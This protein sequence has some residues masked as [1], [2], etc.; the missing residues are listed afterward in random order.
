MPIEISPTPERLLLVDL[1]ERE[2]HE[3]RGQLVD[4]G[5]EVA[6]ALNHA[7]A[8]VQLLTW[9]AHGIIADGDFASVELARLAEQVRRAS[10]TPVSVIFLCQ[11]HP[12][13]EVPATVLLKPIAFLDLLATL[14]ASLA[15]LDDAP[16][17]G[18]WTTPKGE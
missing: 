18:G 1:S 6:V 12:G 13:V 14:R 17:A 10:P 9:R 5:Y 7:D 11:H 16:I 3:L 15:A 2:R 4:A 8:W